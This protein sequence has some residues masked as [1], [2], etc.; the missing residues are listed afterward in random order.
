MIYDKLY[1]KSQ[2]QIFLILTI[3]KK[4]KINV[5]SKSYTSLERR[6]FLNTTTEKRIS[7]LY[8]PGQKIEKDEKNNL[9][10]THQLLK[11]IFDMEKFSKKH[12][13]MKFIHEKSDEL[14]RIIGDR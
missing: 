9:P 12:N 1:D 7:F 4:G 2:C 10:R 3:K 11:E 8:I 5:Y 6:Q 13:Y 14:N